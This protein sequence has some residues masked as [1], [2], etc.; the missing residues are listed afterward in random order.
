MFNF[1]C[2][3][4]QGQQIVKFRKFSIS[5]LYFSNACSKAAKRRIESMCED[6]SRILLAGCPAYDELIKIDKTQYQQAFKKFVHS[7]IN[8]QL[9]HC[10]AKLRNRIQHWLLKQQAGNGPNRHPSRHK[11]QGIF[12]SWNTQIIERALWGQL[13]VQK[14]ALGRKT[15]QVGPFCFYID[16]KTRNR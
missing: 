14:F 5:S 15:F 2:I 8:S 9:F 13:K 1:S 3:L 16:W 10:N 12:L 7:S 11:R 4:F 6:S